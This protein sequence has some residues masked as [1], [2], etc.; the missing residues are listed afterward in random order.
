MRY[1]ISIILAFGLL[2]VTG[3]ASMMKT[4]KAQVCNSNGGYQQGM[5]DARDGKP[6]DQ[7]FSQVCDEAQR[8]QA[9][10]GYHKGYKDGLDSVK[11]TAP[12]TEINV[13]IGN[14]SAKRYYCEIH[15]FTTTISS[16]GS[17]ELEARMKVKHK[18]MQTY[19]EMFCEDIACKH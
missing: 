6:M 14:N 1:G 16:W 4:Y 18:C 8:T 13:N 3:C 15:P 17:T 12:S 2:S 5:N 9:I 10:N 7:S 11:K 19:N